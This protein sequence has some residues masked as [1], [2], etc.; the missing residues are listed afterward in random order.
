M[1]KVIFDIYGIMQN[2][3]RLL[4]ME[5]TWHKNAWQGA[6]YIDGSAH[7]KKD[8]L[9][10]KLYKNQD[11]RSMVYVH[12]QGG[13][14]LTIIEWLQKYGGAK[15]YHEAVRILRNDSI[16]SYSLER[17]S[18]KREEK[19]ARYVPVSLWRE[20]FQNDYR[21]SP[22]FRWFCEYYDEKDVI[23][24]WHMYGITVTQE[25]DVVFWYI[26][27]DKNICHDKRIRYHYDGHRDKEYGCRRRYMSDA[28]YRHRCPFGAHLISDKPIYCVE[29][30]KTCLLCALEYPDKTFLAVGGKNNV[31]LVKGYEC[32]LLP[33]MDAIDLWSAFGDVS[34]WWESYSGYDIGATAD[35]GDLII[36][37][38]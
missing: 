30:E 21:R 32:T 12:E 35:I 18:V 24:V 28:G 2:I 17:I 6:Y 4:N 38:K 14:S 11:G 10:V 19:P 22:L 5:L 27:K 37:D 8:K 7:H 1:G 33:D 13:E 9:R 25:G 15:D 23:H 26:D 36:Q 20:E 16:P 31:S 29:S 34:P 3:P